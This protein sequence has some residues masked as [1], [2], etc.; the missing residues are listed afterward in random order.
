MAC[1]AGSRRWISSEREQLPERVAK[2]APYFEAGLHQLAGLPQV[3]DIPALF[4]FA[5]ALQLEAYL[6]SPRAR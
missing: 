6:G 5:G 4:G 1:A 2:L 3:A